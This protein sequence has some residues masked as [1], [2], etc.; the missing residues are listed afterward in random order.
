MTTL[1]ESVIECR[2]FIEAFQVKEKYLD[3]A[4]KKDFQDASIVVQEQATKLF[5]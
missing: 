2:S 5:K 3:R 1:H 4:F